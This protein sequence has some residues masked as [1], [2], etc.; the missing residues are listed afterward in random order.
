MQV[1]DVVTVNAPFDTA[2]PDVYTVERIEE[3]GDGSVVYF[4]EGIEGAF[5]IKYLESA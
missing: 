4:L 2:F 1:G 5:D 3:V